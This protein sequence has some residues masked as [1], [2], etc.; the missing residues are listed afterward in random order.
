MAEAGILAPDARVELI[1]GEIIDMAPIGKTHGGVVDYLNQ[2]IAAAVDS[3]ALVRVQGSIS[4]DFYSEA[5]PDLV[6]LKPRADY[7]CSGETN[8]TADAIY[9]LIEVS[10]SSERYD[11]TVKQPLYASHGVP[12]VMLIVPD[13]ERVEHHSH[14]EN[15]TCINSE[16]LTDLSAV[17]L[18]C[19]EGYKVDLSW[20]RDRPR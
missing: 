2:K 12:A 16:S 18:G 20:L 17:P 10:E 7:Y 1:N 15:G 9:R 3:A 4:L 13:E 8:P 5:Q 6:L 11:R 14:P 19:L